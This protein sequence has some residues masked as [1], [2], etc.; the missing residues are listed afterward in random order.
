MVGGMK[1]K[2]IVL[3]A[4]LVGGTMARDL[5]ADDAFEVTSAD[6]NAENLRKLESASGVG[7]MQVDLGDPARV[8]EL[9]ARFDIV[10]GALPSRIGFQTLRRSEEH[11][12]ELQSR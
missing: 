8:R 1:T 7:T 11:T 4:G 9:V 5:A 10:L 6:V 3:G 2:S 12:S